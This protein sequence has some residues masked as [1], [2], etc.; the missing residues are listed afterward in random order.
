LLK[1]VI[2]STNF[3]IHIVENEPIDSLVKE[4]RETIDKHK[5]REINPQLLKKSRNLRSVFPNT[6]VIISSFNLVIVCI[7]HIIYWFE[8]KSTVLAPDES[9]LF[10]IFVVSNLAPA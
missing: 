8:S 7:S 4:Y 10:L 9:N 2:Y 3:T 1:Q 5:D 6:F